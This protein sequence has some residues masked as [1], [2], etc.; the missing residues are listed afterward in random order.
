MSANQ[1][2]VLGN[3]PR[4]Q[5]GQAGS[6]ARTPSAKRVAMVSWFGDPAEF[7]GCTIAVYNGTLQVM[8]ADGPIAWF[9]H[10]IWKTAYYRDADE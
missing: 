8:N 1:D 2:G 7:P 9:A 10:G 5:T 6:S 4:M 3:L